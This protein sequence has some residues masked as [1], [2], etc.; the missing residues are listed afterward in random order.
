[1]PIN[2]QAKTISDII[3]I[4]VIDVALSAAKAAI[5]GSAPWTNWP[6]IKQIIDGLM[7]YV[8]SKFCLELQRTGVFLT[9]YFQVEAQRRAYQK[10]EARIR[11]EYYARGGELS[12]ESLEEF[13]HALR[14]LIAYNGDVPV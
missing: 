11:A 10:A 6:V 4:A 13:K 12:P 7:D 14:D 5:H 3:H 8:V 2:D 9:I 1:M